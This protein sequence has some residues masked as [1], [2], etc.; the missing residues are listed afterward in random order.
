MTKKLPGWIPLADFAD[1]CRADLKGVSAERILENVPVLHFRGVSMVA[2]NWE[3]YVFEQK[4]LAPPQAP[5]VNELRELANKLTEE[6]RQ[7]RA[8]QKASRAANRNKGHVYFIQDSRGLWK[9]G[10]STDYRSRFGAISTG[11]PGCVVRWVIDSD[12]ISGLERWFHK[13]FARQR[14]T[15]EWFGLTYR[16][17]LLA[18]ASRALRVRGAVRPCEKCEQYPCLPDHARAVFDREAKLAARLGVSIA[19][20]RS[21]YQ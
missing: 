7:K 18:S 14:K 21:K 5:F 11:N 1:Q 9:I 16:G 10:K 6:H 8:E 15:G 17:R 2:A 12:D 20:V 3:R 13:Q 4:H 19:T